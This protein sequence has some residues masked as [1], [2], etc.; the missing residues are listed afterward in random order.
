MDVGQN[1]HKAA[2]KR[3]SS[4]SFY[5][6]MRIMPRAQRSAMYEIYAFCRAVDDIA[7]GHASVDWKLAHL[8]RW[9]SDIDACFAQRN[10]PPRVAAL[11]DVVHQFGLKRDD[12]LAVIDGMEMDIYGTANAPD[13]ATLDLYCDRVASAV[14]RLSVRVFG[15]EQS[16]GNALAH[17]LGRAL[18]LTNILRDVDEDAAD[19]RIYIAREALEA[20]NLARAAPQ[21]MIGDPRIEAA[22]QET[23]RRARQHFMAS[24]VILS[25][26][27][28]QQVRTPR[29]MASAY[30][31]ML[32]ELVVRGW[33]PP[34]TPIKV[35]RIR[36][37]WLLFRHTI[38]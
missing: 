14:G 21:Q 4:S 24:D 34:R 36:L 2:E 11:S 19:G 37:A 26:C 20:A 23:A 38:V 32:D 22:C 15:M 9:R 25:L 3:A 29:I 30:G 17:H 27:P 18:Q 10:V 33:R 16:A 12:F 13:W 6:A 28:R 35:G 31:A 5:L 7:D 8:R 1:L